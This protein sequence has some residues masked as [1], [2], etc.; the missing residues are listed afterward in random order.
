MAQKLTRSVSIVANKLSPPTISRAYFLKRWRRL[1]N[2]ARL[3][4]KS[5][6]NEKKSPNVVTLVLQYLASKKTAKAMADLS[7]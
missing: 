3:W 6:P 5:S 7:S 4:P 1:K 2:I